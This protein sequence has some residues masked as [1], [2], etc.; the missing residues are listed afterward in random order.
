MEP[1]IQP[2]G[3]PRP[4]RVPIAPQQLICHCHTI[5]DRC[6]NPKRVDSLEQPP[7]QLIFIYAVG[8]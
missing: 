8:E 6:R 7:V 2:P 4:T 1:A 3:P 5:V